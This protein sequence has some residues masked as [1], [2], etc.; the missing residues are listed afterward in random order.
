MPDISCSLKPRALRNRP[1]V[2]LANKCPE[3]RIL[4]NEKNQWMIL[5]KK[6]ADKHQNKFTV[7]FYLLIYFLINLCIKYS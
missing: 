3:G 6:M 2:R 4:V 7:R 1:L 5:L